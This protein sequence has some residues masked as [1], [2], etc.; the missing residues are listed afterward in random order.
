ML[1]RLCTTGILFAGLILCA[2][3]TRSQEPNNEPQKP[4]PAGPLENSE[5]MASQQQGTDA[6]ATDESQT[7]PSRPLAGAQEPRLDT[8]NHSFLLPSFSVIS[9]VRT[10]PYGNAVSNNSGVLSATFLAGRLAVDKVNPQSELLLDYLAGGRFSNNRSEGNTAIQDLDFA[11]TFHFG[12]WT[13]LFGDKFSY[14]SLSTF[15]FGGI[16]GLSNL[17]ITLP[18]A[19]GTNPGFNSE[20]SPDQTI[21]TSGQPRI[22]NAFIAQTDYALGP[23]SSLTFLGSYGVLKF[24]SSALENSS[25]MFFRGGYN[26]ALDEKD[27]IAP[28]YQFSRYSFFQGRVSFDTHRFELTYGRAITG[29]LNFW[30]GAG[31]VVEV[32]KSALAGPRSLA[33]WTLSTGLRYHHGYTGLGLD[34]DRT[35][36]GGS[37]ILTG[38]ETNRVQ[39]IVTRTFPG[40]WDGSILV[41]HSINHA[42]QQTTLNADALSPSAWF[43]TT[44]IG[45]HFGGTGTLAFIYTMFK[46]TGTAT[47]CP[48]TVCGSSSLNHTISV[49]YSWAFHP[50]N[51]E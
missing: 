32:F 49:A 38:A 18:S 14:L 7:G 1:G 51:I 6:S 30:I 15:G 8:T 24:F 41:G 45:H 10:N 5:G 2:P 34:F 44:R 20:L 22:S 48:I 47:V 35:L 27:S 40:S 26:Y 33:D 11:G 21:V 36:T 12:R 9:Q 37:G 31:P 23:R 3:I 17:G 42:L 46:Q 25:D 43:V 28:F 50:I 16:G 39:G 4:A 29:R 19:G 13:Q